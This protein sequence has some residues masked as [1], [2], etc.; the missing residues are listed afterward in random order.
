MARMPLREVD[1]VEILTLLDTIDIL[2]ADTPQPS[3]SLSVLMPSLAKSLV[4][5]HGSPR[6]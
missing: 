4:A 6:W 2:V 5:E 1:K 3:D